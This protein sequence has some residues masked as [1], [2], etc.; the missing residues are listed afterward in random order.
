ML[1]KNIDILKNEK[2]LLAFSHGSDSTALFYIL[3]NASI[4]F[5]L[6]F[7]NYKTRKQSDEEENSARELADKFNKKIFIKVVKL[8]L[9]S[10]SNFEKHARDIRWNF[11]EE[12]A[13]K[14]GYKNIITAHQLN[15]KFE[16]FL[17]Q[18]SKG[19][20]L[21]ELLGMQKIDKKEHFNIIRPLL[22]VSKQEILNFLK[23]NNIHFFHD[24]SNDNVKF[25]RNFIRSKFSDEFIKLYANGLKKSFCILQNDA[26]N[27]KS[28]LVFRK[29]DLFIIKNDECFL[30][31]ID[32]CLKKLG[33]VIS[34]N[35]RKNIT[36]SC[37]IG[38]KFAICK[39]EKY[40]FICPFLSVKMD[41]KFKE[42]CRVLRV[43]SK[44]RPYL[45]AKEI[46]PNNLKNF[47]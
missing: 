30:R 12:L 24:S 36:Q 47:L 8:D 22:D 27:L 17:M 7:V 44:I 45:F 32:K 19:A 42:I 15:D 14:F 5:D 26:K 16:W 43:P 35:Q 37:V 9:Q 13:L 3:E 23:D 28:E 18:F 31:G 29:Y 11:F 38:G 21:N 39:N 1:L 20:G 10:S 34:E 6:A 40:I 41:K 4:N 46:N 2:N 25:K 33:Y